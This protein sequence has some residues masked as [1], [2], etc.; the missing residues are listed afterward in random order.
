MAWNSTAPD[1]TKSVKLNRPILQANTTYTEAEMNK[2]HYWN[3]G[4]NEDG[5]HKFVQSPKVAADP[6]VAGGMDG[7]TYIR[8]VSATATSP[9]VFYRNAGNIY[10]ISPTYLNGTVNLPDTSNFHTVV[11]V[12]NNTYG[13]VYLYLANNG[14]NMGMG[15][16]KAAGGVVQT[17]SVLTLIGDANTAGWNF[18]FGNETNVNGLNIRVKKPTIAAGNYLYKVLYWGL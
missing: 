12:P 18:R 14:Q 16:F 1:G 10:Q 15:Y 2:D 6:A 11:A 8:Q 3:I 9:E 5:R 13:Y 17:Y 4:V 7:V